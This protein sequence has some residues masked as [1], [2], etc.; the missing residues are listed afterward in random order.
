MKLPPVTSALTGPSTVRVGGLIAWP[1]SVGV[2]RIDVASGGTP[3]L[4]GGE[5]GIALQ[6]EPSWE[7]IQLPTADAIAEGMLRIAAGRDAMAAAARA[8]AVAALDIQPWLA[9]HEAVFGA[10]LG[11]A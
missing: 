1:E 7:R 2:R 6:V 5:A 4:V 3:E 8:R 10:L 9:R 11:G